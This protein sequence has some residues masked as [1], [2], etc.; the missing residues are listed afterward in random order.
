MATVVLQPASAPVTQLA[1]GD[2]DV[3]LLTRLSLPAN[4]VFVVTE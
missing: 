1:P 2:V 3:T 4:V